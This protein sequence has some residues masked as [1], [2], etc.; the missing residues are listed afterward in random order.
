MI[1]CRCGGEVRVVDG[2]E[3]DPSADGFHEI[4]ECASCGSEGFLKVR[5]GHT[6]D[7]SGCLVR[8]ETEVNHL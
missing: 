1:R 4:Y 8:T 5:F 2:S 6:A 3:P 7:L